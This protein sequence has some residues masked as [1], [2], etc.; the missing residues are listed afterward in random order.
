M[1]QRFPAGRGKCGCKAEGFPPVPAER[2]DFP[3]LLSEKAKWLLSKSSWKAGGV[4]WR[5]RVRAAS[6]RGPAGALAVTRSAPPLPP[7]LARDTSIDLRHNAPGRPPRFVGSGVDGAWDP[8][9]DPPGSGWGA[10]QSW[11]LRLGGPDGEGRMGWSDCG[12][13]RAGAE[14]GLVLVGASSSSTHCSAPRSPARPACALYRAFPPG[15]PRAPAGLLPV[16]GGVEGAEGAEQPGLVARCV[17]VCTCLGTAR[18]RN[19][20]SPPPCSPAPAHPGRRSPFPGDA[21]V[22][23]SALAPPVLIKWDLQGSPALRSWG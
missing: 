21:S 20:A 14:R 4:C 8:Q 12:V 5:A 18:C 13:C 19:A 9:Q 17:L 11:E 7:G 2:S 15:L 1:D 6:P 16:P 22:R 23:G 3:E 10:K